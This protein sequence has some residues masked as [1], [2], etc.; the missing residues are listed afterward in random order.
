M[1]EIPQYD[2]RLRSEELRS[3]L[4]Y[5]NRL[6]YE[7]DAP[8]IPDAIYDE[9]M[10]ELRAIERQF[11][12]LITPDSPTQRTGA[13]PLTTFDVVEHRLPLLS[14]SNCF[15]EKELNAWHRRAEERV[16][17]A[18]FALTSEPKVDGLAITLVYENGRFAQGATRGDGQRGENVTENLRTIGS[19]P[20]SLKGS[21][22]ARFEVRGEV[23]MPKSGFEAMND[24]IGNTN[25]EREKEGRKPL[26]LYSNPRNAAAGSV[27]QKD[28]AVTAGRPLAM[29]MYQL[30]WCEGARPDSHFETLMWLGEMGFRINPEARR[31]A[32]L[33]EAYER[34]KWWDGQREKLDYDIDGVVLKID[35]TRD[36]ERLGAVG[37]EPRW[38]TA[39]KYPPQQRTTKLR[40]IEV[41]VGRTGVLTPF[42]MLETVV[43]GGANVS[44]A[45]LHNEDDIHRKDIRAGDTVIVQR[46]GEVIPQ[47][48][49][50]VLSLRTGDELEFRMPAE[51]PVCHTPVVREPGEAATYCPNTNCPAQQIRLIEHFTSRGAMDIEGIGERMAYT[52]YRGGL[53]TD[54]AHVYDLTAEKLMTLPL[55]KEKTAGILM[56]GI[57]ASKQRPLPNV[58][59]ALGIRHVGYETARLLAEH[60]GSLEALLDVDSEKLMEVEGIG[61]VVAKSIA[62]WTAREPNRDIV[63]RLVAAGVNPSYSAAAAKV[64]GPLEGLTLLVTGRLETMSRGQAEDRIRALGGK[65]GSSVSKGTDYLVVGAEAGTKL[66]K[67]EKLGVKTIDE[68]TFGNLLEGGLE[69]LSDAQDDPS[70]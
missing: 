25:L 42:A 23:Y 45:T 59:F 38:A 44:M 11:P 5:H 2:A 12:E 37:R 6:Y 30:G 24:A 27:R 65:V 26:P 41:N 47:V 9:L 13:A 64:S 58:L 66:A 70:P 20:R 55:V 53:V 1:A 34:V 29:F 28:P 18:E 31:H 16:G 57:E 61:P 39:F 49:G 56:A 17:S 50:P 63:R 10:N 43:V 3:Q 69:A 14:L 35:D 68:A 15:A 33:A 36:W 46:A 22:P 19:I 48:V 67:A 52:L 32:T 4:N 8:E 40:K 7:M 54:I 60:L 62:N 51:C 21:F